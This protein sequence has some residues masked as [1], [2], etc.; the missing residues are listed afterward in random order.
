MHSSFL[1]VS[2]CL[3]PCILLLQDRGLNLYCFMYKYC[4]Y[5]MFV[6]AAKLHSLC[7]SNFYY[8]IT[9]ELHV[10]HC[11]ESFYENTKEILHNFLIVE[12]FGFHLYKCYRNFQILTQKWYQLS[13]WR[14]YPEYNYQR[15]RQVQNDI[16]IYQRPVDLTVKCHWY[17]ATI[18]ACNRS[19]EIAQMNS[20]KLAIVI[21]FIKQSPSLISILHSGVNNTRPRPSR[22]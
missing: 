13:C 7:P 8:Y 20:T 19:L 2:L 11:L 6:A 12:T 21:L 17:S 10:C 18:T 22:I 14:I 3:N 16:R 1:S 9:K 4:A 5:C 15:Q